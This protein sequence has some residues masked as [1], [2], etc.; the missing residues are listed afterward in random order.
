MGPSKLEWEL[1]CQLLTPPPSFLTS[2]VTHRNPVGPTT[3]QDIGKDS[4]ELGKRDGQL[5][6]EGHVGKT[7]WIPA[8]DYKPQTPILPGQTGQEGFL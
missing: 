7:H 1:Q 6:V 5:L 4:E 3:T 2:N 8:E